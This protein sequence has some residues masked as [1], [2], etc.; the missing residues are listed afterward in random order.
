MALRYSAS[1]VDQMAR[2]AAYITAVSNRIDALVGP[3]VH[4]TVTGERHDPRG[5]SIW[6]RRRPVASISS[7]TEYTAGVAAVLTAESLT[8][9]GDYRV[10]QYEDDATMLSGRLSRRSGFTNGWWMSGR[11][12]TVT[13]VAGRYAT[14]TAAKDSRFYLAAV[15][16][17]KSLWRAEVDSVAVVNDYDQVQVPMPGFAI[18]NAAR[19]LL[20][21]QYDYAGLA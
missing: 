13:Y 11:P 16:T 19:E 5:A 12:V 17:L 21:D 7:V 3:V 4:R 2:V 15:L 10:D 14:T 1:N 6:L 20:I 18:P 9:A 8:V